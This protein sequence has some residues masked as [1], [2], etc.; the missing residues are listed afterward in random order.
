[1]GCSISTAG[2][3]GGLAVLTGTLGKAAAQ[4]EGRDQDAG[5]LL[6]KEQQLQLEQPR[7][8]LLHLCGVRTAA[9]VAWQVVCVRH[10]LRHGALRVQC[11]WRLRDEGAAGRQQHS[12]EC[13]PPDHV[14]APKGNLQEVLVQQGQAK[15]QRGKGASHKGHKARDL[16]G[17]AGGR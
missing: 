10:Q 15:Q 12:R 17:R 8:G 14:A 16:G 11:G 1:M 4:D 2:A 5:Q 13:E 9:P 3:R 6:G 7:H